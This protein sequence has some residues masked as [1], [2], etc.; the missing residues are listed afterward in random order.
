MANASDSDVTPVT[1][2]MAESLNP[3]VPLHIVDSDDEEEDINEV[4]PY[5]FE[6]LVGAEQLEHSSSSDEEEGAP[7]EYRAERVGNTDWYYIQQLGFY[8]CSLSLSLS[9]SLSAAKQQLT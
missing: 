3:Q 7:A 8:S 4:A 2:T 1:S 9:L 5:Q 6:P